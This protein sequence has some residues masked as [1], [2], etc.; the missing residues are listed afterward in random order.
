M[1]FLNEAF[2]LEI[3]NPSVAS[4]GVKIP[5]DPDIIAYRYAK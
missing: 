4:I 3:S 1:N 5:F 2:I